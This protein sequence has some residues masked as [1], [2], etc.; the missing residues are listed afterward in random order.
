MTLSRF[1]EALKRVLVHE[2]GY[3]DHPAD[4]GGATMK[5]VTQRVYDAF[6]RRQGVVSRPVALIE[7]VELKAIYRRQYW[8]RCGATSF[9]P[10]S[11]TAFSMRR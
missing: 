7:S 9:Q 6:R 5:G 4:P 1:D 2:G 11:T 8:T 10:G 3:V